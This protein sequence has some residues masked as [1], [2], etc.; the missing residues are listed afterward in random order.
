M[1][2]FSDFQKLVRF[3]RA[4]TIG[5]GHLKEDFIVQCN[6]D[7]QRC[8]PENFKTGQFDKLGN[9][10]SFNSV[11]HDISV[12]PLNTSQTG[13]SFGLKL[14]LFIDKDEYLGIAG[15]FSGAKLIISNPYEHPSRF[16]ESINLAAGTL[17]VVSMHQ[18][19]LSRQSSPYSTCSQSWPENLELNHMKDRF[20]YTVPFC[21]DLCMRNYI[22][23]NCNCSW[24]PDRI[25]SS[26]PEIIERSRNQC[27]I[28]RPAQ[29]ACIEA[30]VQ[31]FLN[32]IQSC[33]CSQECSKRKLK[34][35]S[36]TS[37]WPSEAYTPY[38][39]M[40]LEKSHST[41]V[42]DFVMKSLETSRGQNVVLKS[43]L[44]ENFVRVE[45]HFI[46][47]DFTHIAEVPKY[48]MAM[49]FGTLGGNLGLWLGWSLMTLFEMFQWVYF[50]AKIALNQK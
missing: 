36:S 2:D 31:Q 29:R 26:N 45:I 12:P 40:L 11:Q 20:D 32:E 3:T 19:L 7:N 4:E 18:E 48:N 44:Q 16:A 25:Y 1:P 6:F 49:L 8:G 13:A 30:S 14:T 37:E 21:E 46:T 27:H 35:Y 5:N 38:L 10:F 50:C 23:T 39:A 28:W 17:T 34:F 43:I 9:C 33:R 41:A 47:L 22:A 24:D 42:F 15:Q